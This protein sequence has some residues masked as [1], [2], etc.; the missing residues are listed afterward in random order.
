MV[1]LMNNVEKRLFSMRISF[2]RHLTEAMH[3][4]MKSGKDIPEESVEKLQEVSAAL[5]NHYRKNS[6]K[7]S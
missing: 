4:T 3:E 7:R 1:T 6:I 5:Y 2:L